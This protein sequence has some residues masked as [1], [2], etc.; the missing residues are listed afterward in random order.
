MSN[1][2]V[3]VVADDSLIRDA[4]ETRLRSFGFTVTESVPLNA[5]LHTKLDSQSIPT[6]VVILDTD[7]SQ[8]RHAVHA[9]EILRDRF[10]SPVLV[11]ADNDT[12]VSDALDTVESVAVLK[13][14]FDDSTLSS[15]VRICAKLTRALRT[16]NV[17]AVKPDA[18]ITDTTPD[19]ATSDSKR[20]I[21]EAKKLYVSLIELSP[22]SVMV[23]KNGVYTYVNPAGLELLGYASMSEIAGKSAEESVAP[24]SLALVRERL[25]KTTDD[26]R[27]EPVEIVILRPDGTRRNVVSASVTIQLNGDTAVLVIGHDIT[28]L[29]TMQNAL[30]T[31]E[32]ELEKAQ[33]MAH[34]GSYTW[35]IETGEA[36][37]SSE[38]YELFGHPEGRPGHD[39]VISMIHPEDRDLV[40]ETGEACRRGNKQFVCDYRIVL[41]DGTIRYV[42]DQSHVEYGDDGEPVRMFG[43][44]QDI[45]DRKIVESAYRESEEKYRTLVENSPDLIIRF[46]SEGTILFA[47]RTACSIIGR[48]PGECIGKSPEQAGLPATLCDYLEKHMPH[49][50]NSGESLDSVLEFENTDG[51]HVCNWRLIPDHDVEGRIVNILGIGSDITGQFVAEREY[52]AI[53]SQM[54]DGFALHEIILDNDGLPFDYRFL[55]IN[56]AFED[57][58]G[59]KSEDIVGKTALEIFPDLESN[60]IETYGHV[61]M[62]GEPARFESGSQVLGKQFEVLAYCP[63]KGFFAVIFRDITERMV[64]ENAL[65]ESEDKLSSL[66]RAAPIG[67][68]V[69]I[70]RVLRIVNQRFC[71]LLGYSADELI[72]K[73]SRMLYPTDEDYEFVGRAKYSQI[74][75]QG[76]GTVETRMVKKDGTVIEILLSSTPIDTGDLRKGVTFTALDITDR[77]RSEQALKESE[78][79]FRALFE[80]APIGAAVLDSKGL[81]MLANIALQNMLGYSADEL[82]GRHFSE[83]SFQDDIED[84]M[85]DFKRLVDGTLDFYS[86][87]KRYIHKDGRILWGS[88]AVSVS[89]DDTGRLVSIVAMIEDITPRKQLE[90]Q[91]RQSQKME[92]IG[93]LAGGIAHDFNNILSIIYGY[94]ELSLSMLPENSPITRDLHEIMRASQRAR[95][96]V[97]QILTISRQQK[98][99]R[100]PTSMGLIAKEIAKFLRA[101]LPSTIE[102]VPKVGSNIRS[103]MADPIQ[104]HQVI[105]NLC[106]NAAHAMRRDGGT[107]EIGIDNVEI[108]PDFVSE[109]P[110]A[111]PGASVRITVRD[112]G[113][114]I[115]REHIERIFEPYF[116]TKKKGEGTGLGLAVVLGIVHSHNGVVTVRSEIGRGTEFQ[117][118][119]PAVMEMNIPEEQDTEKFSGGSGH[120]LFVDDEPMLVKTEKRKLERLG[121]KVTAATDGIEAYSIFSGSPD[122]FDLI[123]TDMTMPKMTGLELARKIEALRS[124]LPVIVCTGYHETIMSGGKLGGNIR[125]VLIKPVTL[126]NLADAVSK[127]LGG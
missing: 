30:R 124:D 77:K 32:Q 46:S 87:E 69:V 96:L 79:L 113:D 100:K 115:S 83:I 14:P 74:R 89:R 6:D 94:T 25:K 31:S 60:W 86:M 126:K 23:I 103:I 97:G 4:L 108:G 75:K 121:Y 106:T 127:V 16:R 8:S 102:I 48:N 81:I 19:S 72:G 114:G 84:E 123:V 85:A 107:L 36:S 3:Y 104:M 13:K 64:S 9:V 116:T 55:K 27:N 59:L 7:F 35:D 33:H 5:A 40:R 78:T 45:T 80:H 37:W 54:L 15:A 10:R 90:V 98:E 20:S 41:P 43:T 73:T 57:M 118:F 56:P 65:R 44:L 49:V 42:H 2:R 53:F 62:T 17:P 71:D 91:L 120:I 76:T 92:A 58:T 66:F 18:E 39:L 101:S 88:L 93:T 119:F 70:D 1:I 11:L 34:L 63:R 26:N 111:V 95:D 24:E 47:N 105:M 112:T 122:A 61:A 67:I 125:E 68:G 82:K 21:E 29:K 110:G 109:H 52:E 51:V 99:E 22:G 50:R 28:E 12:L 117:V 38:M